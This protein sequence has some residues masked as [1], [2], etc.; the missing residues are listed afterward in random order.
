MHFAGT[1]MRN[2]RTKRSAGG[3]RRRSTCRHRAPCGLASKTLGTTPI[4]RS[5]ASAATARS[6]GR[7]SSS[8]SAE[9][10]VDERIAIVE[11]ETGDHVVPFCDMD[12]GLINRRGMFIRFAPPREGLRDPAEQTAQPN[13][14]GIYAGLKCRQS[15]RLYPAD[16]TAKNAR[17]GLP[18]R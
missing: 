11:L 9:A 3:H 2:V 13:L 17:L 16:V 10:L 4:T 8:S 5:A 15:F 7:V 1:T 6:D 12:I 14:L 18:E